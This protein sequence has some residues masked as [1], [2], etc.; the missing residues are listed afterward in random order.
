MTRESVKGDLK[1][2]HTKMCGVR[3]CNGVICWQGKESVE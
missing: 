2:P 3:P 1:R